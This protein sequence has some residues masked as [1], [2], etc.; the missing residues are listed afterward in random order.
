MSHTNI[1][2]PLVEKYRQKNFNKRK[3]FGFK[4]GYLTFLMVKRT[5]RSIRFKSHRK[6]KQFFFKCKMQIITVKTEL[7]TTSK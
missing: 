7:T 2:L 6:R 4:S 1:K 3:P 5:N